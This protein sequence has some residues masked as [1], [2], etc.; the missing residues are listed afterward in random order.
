[1]IKQSNGFTLMELMVAVTIVAILASIAI[2]SY[3]QYVIR[4]N[5]AA[6]QAE[7]MQIANSL[8]RY[9]AQQL[10]YKNAVIG[11]AT[12]G[13]NSVYAAASYPATGTILYNFE[14]VVAANNVSWTLTAKPVST[15]LQKGN[16][17]LQ[18]NNTGLKCWDQTSD[19]TVTT[20]SPWN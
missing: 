20:C 9:R 7:L 2:P 15:S 1:M 18:I 6:A 14:L 8:E 16:G 3:R 17:V 11:A 10:S 13:K 4:N 5:R 12:T 19:T